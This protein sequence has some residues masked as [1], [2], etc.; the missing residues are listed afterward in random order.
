MKM[1]GYLKSGRFSEVPTEYAQIYSDEEYCNLMI[2]LI[3]QTTFMLA[4]LLERQQ[5]QFLKNGGI[6]ELMFNAR[7]N[8]RNGQ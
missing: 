3:N 1:R 7:T 5:E 8:Y 2:T 4:R 6:N